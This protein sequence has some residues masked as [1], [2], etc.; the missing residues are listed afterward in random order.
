MVGLHV[1][2]ALGP[3]GGVRAGGFLY[4][5]VDKFEHVQGSPGEAGQ[6]KRDTD[7]T[8]D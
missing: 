6:D 7:V 1:D 4:H 8:C 5:K 2:R 3:E